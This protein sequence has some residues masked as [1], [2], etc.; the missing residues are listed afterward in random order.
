MGVDGAMRVVRQ[1]RRM[2]SK[3]HDDAPG[4]GLK[5]HERLA[6]WISG[7]PTSRT[8]ASIARVAGVTWPS[9]NAW[10][11]GDALPKGRSAVLL[12]AY[13]GCGVDDLLDAGRPWPPREDDPIGLIRRLVPGL[14]SDEVAELARLAGKPDELRDFLRY[15]R[16]RRKKDGQ[17]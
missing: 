1:V 15:S 17:S 2:A 12:A 9:A 8:V 7:D 14:S 3:Q 10:V 16:S 11:S 4:V 6:D 13:I 5:F